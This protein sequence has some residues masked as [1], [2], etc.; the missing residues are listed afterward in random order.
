MAYQFSHQE[1]ASRAYVKFIPH[2]TKRNRELFL[3]VKDK[4]KDDDHII[5]PFFLFR[6]RNLLDNRRFRTLLEK[7]KKEDAVI[8]DIEHIYN[9][10]LLRNINEIH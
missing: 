9:I 2:T 7:H 6:L 10:A 3:W 5:S 8:T 1:K 4:F